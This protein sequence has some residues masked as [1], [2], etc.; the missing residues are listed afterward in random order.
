MLSDVTSKDERKVQKTEAAG[1][2]VCCKLVILQ[3]TK[4]G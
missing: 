3:K 1:S 2:R 4:E